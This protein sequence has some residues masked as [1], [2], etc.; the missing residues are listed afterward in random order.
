MSS[1]SDIVVAIAPVAPPAIAAGRSIRLASL[2]CYRG[3]FQLGPM[4]AAILLGS[5]LISSQQH[6]SSV[7]AG[8]IIV[9][10][11]LQHFPS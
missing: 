2:S 11:I 9:A 1:H 4:E 3:W 8:A 7:V 6:R 5:D 10:R